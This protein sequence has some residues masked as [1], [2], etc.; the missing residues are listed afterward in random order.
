MHPFV[1]IIRNLARS[2]DM[3]AVR[4]INAWHIGV[5]NRKSATVLKFTSFAVHLFPATNGRIV[6]AKVEKN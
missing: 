3:S 4:L 2:D 6:C 1:C 5:Q